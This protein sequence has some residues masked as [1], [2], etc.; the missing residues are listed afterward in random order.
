[1]GGDLNQDA[2]SETG[3]VDLLPGYFQLGFIQGDDV[4][5]D[6]AYGSLFFIHDQPSIFDSCPFRMRI[7]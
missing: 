6:G 1:M 3:Q 7:G 2:G 4:E 5:A